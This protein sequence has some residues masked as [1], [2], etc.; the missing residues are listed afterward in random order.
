MSDLTYAEAVKRLTE[1]MTD[2]PARAEEAKDKEAALLAGDTSVDTFT[3]DCPFGWTVTAGM[4]AR[5][6][7]P[8]LRLPTHAPLGGPTGEIHDDLLALFNRTRKD[9][10]PLLRDRS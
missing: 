4:G 3:V 9:L 6:G 10:E 1:G 5:P 2:L 8:E 7:A